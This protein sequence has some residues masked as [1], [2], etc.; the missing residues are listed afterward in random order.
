MSEK[1]PGEVSLGDTFN[2]TIDWGDSLPRVRELS[3]LTPNLVRTVLGWNDEP[4]L[5]YN[6]IFYIGESHRYRIE[7][8]SQRDDIL[9]CRALRPVTDECMRYRSF[10]ERSMRT[11]PDYNVSEKVVIIPGDVE[12][13]RKESENPIL[14]F[15][16]PVYDWI[17]KHVFKG[18]LFVN[19]KMKVKSLLG[20]KVLARVNKRGERRVFAEFLEKV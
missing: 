18:L 5:S 17:N 10:D 1:F 9:I 14:I 8:V 3:N 16:D 20:E 7:L 11:I 13:S 4:C 12:D 15:Y 19:Q 2:G 6:E